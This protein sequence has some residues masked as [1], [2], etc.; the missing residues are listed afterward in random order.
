MALIWAS[1]KVL[2]STSKPGADLKSLES[3][4]LTTPSRSAVAVP[5]VEVDAEATPGQSPVEVV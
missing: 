1:V 5:E 3:F 2:L 4:S